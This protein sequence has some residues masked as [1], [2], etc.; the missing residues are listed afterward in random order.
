MASFSTALSQA[1]RN[2]CV[3]RRELLAVVQ[4]VKRFHPY[5]YGQRFLIRTDHSALQWL[6]NFR[7][8]KGQTARWL[9]ALQG[10]SFT[11]QHRP[12]SQHS[13]ADALSR[14]PCFESGCKHCNRRDSTEE[15][16]HAAS[17][18]PRPTS[19]QDG[20]SATVRAVALNAHNLTVITG[21]PEELRQ[22]QLTDDTLC[23]V[24]EWLERSTAKP[25]WDEVA[26]CG[27][28]TKVY[29]AQ[30]DSLQLINGVLHRL[31]ET[32]SGD[33]V[34]RQLVV[35]TSLREKVLKELHGSA[36]TGHFSIA[37]TQGR[38]QQRFYWVNCRDDVREWCHNCD[39]CAERR[40]PPRRQ[41][42]AM[43]QYLVGAPMERLGLDVLHGSIPLHTLGEKVHFNCG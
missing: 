7:Q 36:T 9:E 14:R 12:G 10:Y 11:V 43:Q 17:P 2:Y 30:W 27:E 8:P 22:A 35:P 40:G 28:C 24:I 16:H 41:R 6:L 25:D 4:A 33:A 21:S 5:L 37:K 23:P 15:L 34:V 1:Q 20:P 3:T 26:P 38:V 13:N 39:V 19:E 18:D 29:W 32:P 31:W 42:A